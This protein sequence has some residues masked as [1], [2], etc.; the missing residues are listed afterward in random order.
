MSEATPAP[1]TSEIPPP[2][3]DPTKPGGGIRLVLWRFFGA[4]F[5]EEKKN[6]G[7]KFQAV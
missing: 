1:I 6:N 5:M 4:L 2:E 3:A 7:N